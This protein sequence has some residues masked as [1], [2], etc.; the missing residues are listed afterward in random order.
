MEIRMGEKIRALRKRRN[1]SQ[2]V[3]AQYLGVS[4][5][6]VSK[7]ENGAAMPDVAMIPAIASFFDVSTDELFDFNRL[8]MEKR[9]YD[10]VY[11]AADRR[12]DEPREAERILREGLKKYPG[13]DILLNNLLYVLD[14]PER[15]DEMI[16]ICRSLIE[17][18]RD[19]AVKY[20]ACRI[21]AETYAGMGEYELCR[22]TLE[23]IPEIYFTKLEMQALLLKGEEKFKAARAQRNL[24]A[25]TLTDM[26]MCLAEHYE[27]NGNMDMARNKWETAR[28]VILA[29]KDERSDAPDGSTYYSLGGAQTLEKLERKL[30]DAGR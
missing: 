6:A 27:E 17:A 23:L 20:D 2:E 18:T 13:N 29:L 19:D 1:I 7:W 4:F 28:R 15:R 9:I 26:L 16:A 21:L 3:L 30:K 5:Q 8:D 10:I 14:A 11:A 22:Q 12:V 25:E 24:A